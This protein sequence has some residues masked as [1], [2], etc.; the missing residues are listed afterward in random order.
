MVSLSSRRY[1]HPCVCQKKPSTPITSL[2]S[3]KVHNSNSTDNLSRSE[4]IEWV[5]G[6][7][8]LNYSKVEHLCSG[9][10]YCQYMDMLFP[11][12][13]PIKRIKFDAKSV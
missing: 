7:L 1:G 6:L 4:M 10:A 9:A 5:N 13:V 8:S 11:G 3:L 2:F 12:S